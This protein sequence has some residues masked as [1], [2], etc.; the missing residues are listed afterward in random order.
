M[1]CLWTASQPNKLVTEM[2][3]G[4]G[5]HAKYFICLIIIPTSAFLH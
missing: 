2:R 3:K 4:W 1:N 5:D